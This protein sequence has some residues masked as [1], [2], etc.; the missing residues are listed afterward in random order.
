MIDD[1]FGGP[2]RQIEAS[3]T[4]RAARQ[5]LLASNI[6]NSE[7]PGYRALDVNFAA[8]MENVVE[9]MRRADASAGPRLVPAGSAPAPVGELLVVEGS[10]KGSIGNSQNTVD[11][12]AQMARLDENRLMFQ[13]TA[14]LAALRF[15]GLKSILEEGGR[16]R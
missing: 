13:A 8:T 5:E 10:D 7:T 4:V 3:L 11:I 14:Q 15:Q 9:E 1:L 16:A 6:A 12:D 2:L